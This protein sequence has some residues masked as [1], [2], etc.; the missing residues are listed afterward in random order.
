MLAYRSPFDNILDE[1]FVP[2]S[3]RTGGCCLVRSG[4]P[5]ER[6]VVAEHLDCHALSDAEVYHC[7][8]A[9]TRT[10]PGDVLAGGRQGADCGE[11]ISTMASPCAVLTRESGSWLLHM[12]AMARPVIVLVD[13]CGVGDT[14]L[15]WGAFSDVA[16]SGL[17]ASACFPGPA[18][19]QHHP[20]HMHRVFERIK[21][22]AAVMRSTTELLLVA[23]PRSEKLSASARKLLSDTAS[24]ISMCHY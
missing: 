10:R 3:S 17:S 8:F 4:Q 24:D 18:D 11:A 19:R 2:R 7:L 9:G 14:C 12:H 5:G 22:T 1:L 16:V 13:A 20:E 21:F 23:A 6:V 15:V